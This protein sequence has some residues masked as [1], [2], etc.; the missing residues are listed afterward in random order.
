MERKGC[1][2]LLAVAGVLAAATAVGA[3][4]SAAAAFDPLKPVTVTGVI[5]EVRL[6]NPHSWFFVDVTEQGGKVTKW[7]FEGTPPTA[8]LRSGF[9][10]DA[11]KPGD[12]VTV[13]GV[14]SRDTTVN[15]GAAHE[16]VLLSE[17]KTFVV[18][19][20]NGGNN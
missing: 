19:P 1:R 3:H 8:L 16:I 10:R 9:K 4:H 2:A 15:M 5:A 12:K 11:L 6:E 18:G 17:G 14:H 20:R 7:G 13:N